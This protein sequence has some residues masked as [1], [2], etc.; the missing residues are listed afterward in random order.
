MAGNGWE[1]LGMA[2]NG[3]EWLG[4]ARNGWE[5]LGMP[6][7]AR[8]SFFPLAYTSLFNRRSFI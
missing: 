2:G 3:W 8:M 5:W 1:W 4:M 7:N 6:G